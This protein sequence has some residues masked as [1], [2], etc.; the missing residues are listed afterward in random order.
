MILLLSSSL[1]LLVILS[2]SIQKDN[3]SPS[4]FYILFLII[5]FAD[6]FINEKS[7][8]VY[9][10]YMLYIL[11][12]FLFVFIDRYSNNKP[13]RSILNKMVLNQRRILLVLWILTLI[14]ILSQL[15]LISYFGGLIEY[16]A[17]LKLRV[18]DWRGLGIPLILKQIM[19]IVNII[20]LI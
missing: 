14:P 17:S 16:F 5:Y 8:Y 20:F 7:I 2:F 6:I 19:P 4:K 15:Y 10:T 1:F 3:F 11:F 18:L 13:T 12:G 9:V